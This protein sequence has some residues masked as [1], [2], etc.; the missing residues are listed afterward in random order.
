MHHFVFIEYRILDNDSLQSKIH[1]HNDSYEISQIVEGSGNFLIGESPYPFKAGAVYLTKPVQLHCSHANEGHPYIRS[2]LAVNAAYLEQVLNALGIST[3]IDSIFEKDE[4]QYI[5]LP[6]KTA[7]QVDS[8]FKRMYEDSQKKA[9]DTNA[10]ML[11]T[12]IDILLIC[13]SATIST[14]KEEKPI[15][16]PLIFRTIKYINFNISSEL[17]VDI[18]AKELFISKYYLCRKFKKYLGI[19]IMKYILNQRLTLA[20]AQLINSNNKCS[21]IAMST[22]FSS[23]SYFC[24]IFKEEEGVSPSTYRKLHGKRN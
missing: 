13:K 18:I 21:D 11:L 24:R 2:K 19:S 5:P 6:P 14:E 3:Y 20:K 16:D 23:F 12:L 9:P 4:G 1:V 17:T 10:K 22:G 15:S 7:N 8:L